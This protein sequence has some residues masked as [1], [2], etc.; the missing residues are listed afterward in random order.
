MIV[1]VRS[2][3]RN[4]VSW[5]LR[6]YRLSRVEAVCE[7][8]GTHDATVVVQRSIP[9][10][11]S[12]AGC[13]QRRAMQCVSD[14]S[15]LVGWCVETQVAIPLHVISLCQASNCLYHYDTCRFE[16]DRMHFHRQ[17]WEGTW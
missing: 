16:R 17:C 3:L 11:A 6:L 2:R 4:F 12:E 10:L 1:C 8:F 7:S 15:P 14:Q 9:V 13:G 5:I